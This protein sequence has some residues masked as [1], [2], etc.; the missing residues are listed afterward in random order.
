MEH[1]FC[2][3]SSK[4]T[5]GFYIYTTTGLYKIVGLCSINSVLIKATY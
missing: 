2:L 1:M 4:A 3:G 5:R